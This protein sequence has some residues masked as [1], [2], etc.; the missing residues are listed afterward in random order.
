[1][2]RNESGNVDQVTGINLGR[3][4]QI[5][6]RITL[7]LNRGLKFI[8]ELNLSTDR[9][10]QKREI[11]RFKSEVDFKLKNGMNFFLN[12]Y[13]LDTIFPDRSSWNSMNRK[14]S[15]RLEIKI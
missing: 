9:I 12:F 7:K 10:P 1:M 3:K 13:K 6:G 4:N 11:M 15:F 5:G 14:G 8:S 2:G